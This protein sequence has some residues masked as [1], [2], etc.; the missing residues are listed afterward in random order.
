MQVL[1]LLT[2]MLVHPP[3]HVFPES[4]APVSAYRFS[5][6]GDI[7]VFGLCIVM[8]IL[9]SQTHVHKDKQFRT[10][11][12]I[13]I[14]NVI[15]SVADLLYQLGSLHPGSHLIGL[16]A[17]RLIRHYCLTMTILFYTL[18][19]QQ[20]LW[21]RTDVRRRYNILSSTLVIASIFIDLFLSILHVG[22]YITDS[23]A[24][25]SGFNIWIV[26]YILFT[27]VIFYL[28][29]KHR[30]RMI[31]QVFWGL[32]GA[33]LVALT[34]L[35]MQGLH[36]NG[37]FTGVAYFLPVLGLIYLF[38][39]NPYD[40]DTGAVSD[41][42]FYHEMKE[43]TEKRRT[44]V[45]MSCN[46]VNFTKLLKTDKDLKIEFYQFFRVN[47]RHGVLYHFPPDR[48]ILS[49]PK[50]Y[51]AQQDRL[52]EKMLEDFSD[53]HKRFGIDFKIVIMET[54]PEIT[55]SGDYLRLIEYAEQSMPMNSI[56]RIG[57]SDIRGF[58]KSDYIL[59]E[60]EDIAQKKDLDDE[61]VLVYCQPVFNL[62]TKSY[63]TAE[64]LMRLTLPNTGL[65]YPDQFIP[66][67]EQNNLIHNM[68][69]IILNKTCGAVRTLLEDGYEIK[70]VSVNFSTLDMRYE[71]FCQEVQQIIARNQIPYEKIAIE[72]TESRSEQ[73]FHLMKARI[74]ELQKLGIKFYLDDFGTGYSNFERIMEIPFDII[75]FDRSLLIE[76]SKSDSSYYMVSTFAKM[77]NKLEYSILFEGIETESDEHCCVNMC[78]KYL[79]GYKYSKPIPVEELHTFLR[80]NSV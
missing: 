20:P 56:H 45:L 74:M 78:A 34:I 8:M 57:D 65:V 70:R 3:E 47:V 23:G 39:S 53:S 48:L 52:I 12:T 71:S 73:D 54:S 80:H 2:S 28:I 79:Q 4:D 19:L 58:Y 46:M 43:A 62:S 11:I 15:A 55:H 1:S 41:S 26:L 6:V 44:L 37:S 33:N 66:L 32:L 27:A 60:L 16:L 9:V 61:R 18:Y 63:D 68:S 72:I 7:A 29:I 13:L 21:L 50:A 51:A 76:A 17:F 24:I 77:F 38:H 64:A 36:R 59:S 67:A 49:F 42:Y 14:L 22:F 75:K 30:N 10:L 35:L 31:R 25:H 69:M 40:I 5:A